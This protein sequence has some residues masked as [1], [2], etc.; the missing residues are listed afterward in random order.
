MPG[1]LVVRVFGS[2][3]E[4]PPH[5]KVCNSPTYGSRTSWMLFQMALPPMMTV[6]WV[7][8]SIR[9]PPGSHYGK[10]GGSKF[11]GQGE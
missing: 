6:S 5:V 2:W 11:I 7:V 1:S 9:H 4:G 3:P 10:R 8:N